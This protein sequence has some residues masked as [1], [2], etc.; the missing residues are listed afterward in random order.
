MFINFGCVILDTCAVT[1]GSRVLFGPNVSLFA[2][3]HPLDPAVRNGTQG[4]E[5]GKP[6]VI[7][8]DEIGR[9]HV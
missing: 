9:A 2:A 1:I 3:S 5:N 8:D 7:G 6:I 4:P